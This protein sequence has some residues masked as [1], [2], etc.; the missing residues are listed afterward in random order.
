[1]TPGLSAPDARFGRVWKLTF[2]RPRQ[3]LSD[4]DFLAR[5]CWLRGDTTAGLLPCASTP[6]RIHHVGHCRLPSFL[7]SNCWRQIGVTTPRPP[8]ALQ[9][10]TTLQQ[11]AD[12]WAPRP[13]AAASSELSLMSNP[14]IE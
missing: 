6:N 3:G 2:G 11:R 4:D 9:G 1:M 8:H 5:R 13:S 7:A 14:A 10:S 12:R